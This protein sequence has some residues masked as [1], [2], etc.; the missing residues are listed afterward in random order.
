VWQRKRLD[1]WL[2]GVVHDAH[3]AHRRLWQKALLRHKLVPQQGLSG[4]L[5]KRKPMHG[6]AVAVHSGSTAVTAL[7]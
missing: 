3:V 2:S 6:Q 7:H 4:W 5:S 1:D